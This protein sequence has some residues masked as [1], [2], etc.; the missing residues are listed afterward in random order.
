[1]K[2]TCGLPKWGGRALIE[3]SPT[4]PTFGAWRS[5][6]QPRFGPLGPSSPTFVRWFEDGAAERRAIDP[7]TSL[8]RN[9]PLSAAWPTHVFD[10]TGTGV[11]ARNHVAPALGDTRRSA[12][13]PLEPTLLSG[14]H[15]LS[16]VDRESAA[17]SNGGRL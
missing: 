13:H 4:S 10:V 7:G 3:P 11:T 9:H 17:L 1:M 6:A 2:T 16:A 8:L 15:G 5:E 14:K 12:H